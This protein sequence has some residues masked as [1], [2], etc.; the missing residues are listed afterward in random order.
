MW[1]Y[2][3][4]GSGVGQVTVWVVGMAVWWVPASLVVVWGGFLHQFCFVLFFFWI[5]LVVFDVGFA[6]GFV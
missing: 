6:F 5:S 3:G 1:V 2:S 4:V